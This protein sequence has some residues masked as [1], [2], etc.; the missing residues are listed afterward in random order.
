MNEPVVVDLESLNVGDEVPLHGIV[1]DLWVPYYDEHGNPC[2]LHLQN[3]PIAA[4]V[5]YSD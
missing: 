4:L 2:R 1:K 5:D 3:V